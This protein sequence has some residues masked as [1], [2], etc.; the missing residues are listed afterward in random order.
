MSGASVEEDWLV[1]LLS[2]VQTLLRTDAEITRTVEVPKQNNET[3][4]EV[5]PSHPHHEAT[6]RPL[7]PEEPTDT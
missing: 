5:H 1:E 2:D 6:E 4:E 3:V 7:H